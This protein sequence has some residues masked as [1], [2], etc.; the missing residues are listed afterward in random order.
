MTSDQ[1]SLEQILT[2]WSDSVPAGDVTLQTRY[3]HTNT[4]GVVL[5]VNNCCYIEVLGVRSNREG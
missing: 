4:L 2:I 3:R 5:L 1:M